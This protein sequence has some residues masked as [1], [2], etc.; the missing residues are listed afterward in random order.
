MKDYKSAL[1]SQQHALHITLKLF[2][3]DHSD[4]AKS[5]ETI[6]D[7][8][9]EIEDYISTLDA[10]QQALQIRLKLYGKNHPDTA[11]SYDDIELVYARMKSDVSIIPKQKES[12]YWMKYL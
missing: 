3:Q 8:Q 4:T 6:G 10:Y 2:G 9:S 12:P 1:E 11:K 7:T 5:Y